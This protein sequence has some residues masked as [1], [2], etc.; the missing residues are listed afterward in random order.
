MSLMR[1]SSAVSATTSPSM[2][3]FYFEGSEGASKMKA[4]MEK[5]HQNPPLSLDGQE[6]VEVQDYLKGTITDRA[7]HTN[8]PLA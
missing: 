7:G 2:T 3:R 1:N 5:L 8:V 4:I 6:V